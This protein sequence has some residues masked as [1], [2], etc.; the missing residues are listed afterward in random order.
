MS[1]STDRSGFSCFWGRSEAALEG[2][3]VGLIWLL[4]YALLIAVV[5]WIA[6]KLISQFFPP[7]AAYA[8]VVW[9][10]GGLVL[11]LLIVK[12]LLPALPS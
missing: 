3:I 4:V 8:W 11:L 9:A 1:V 5:C 2:L 10:I 7:A 12:L 6:T